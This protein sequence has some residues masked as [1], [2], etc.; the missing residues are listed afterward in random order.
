[1]NAVEPYV[2]AV[3]RLLKLKDRLNA[4][5]CRV[6]CLDIGGGFGADYGGAETLSSADYAAAIVP[7]LKGRSLRIILE[8]GRSIAANAGIMLTRVLYHKQS[9]SKRF[10]I[11]DAG[12]S[13]LL[14]P[15]LY[16]AEHFVWPAKPTEP[17]VPPARSLDLRLDGGDLVDVVGPLCESG[18]FLA[19]NRHLPPAERGELLAVFGAGAYGFSMS[20]HYNSRPLA[21]EVLVDQDRFRIIRARET[22]EDLVRGEE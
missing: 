13:D 14:R 22:Y 5:G 10:V 9:G 21:A 4:A 19:R 8:P 2:R 11:T 3:R 18:D 15:A 16:G 7:L 12:M 1:V 6:D 20:N 17:F